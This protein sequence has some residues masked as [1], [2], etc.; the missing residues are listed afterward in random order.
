MFF[1]SLCGGQPAYVIDSLWIAVTEEPSGSSP[2]L[3]IIHTGDEVNVATIVDGQAQVKTATGRTGWVDASYLTPAPPLSTQFD[4]I[5]QSFQQQIDAIERAQARLQAL[6]QLA[7]PY[8]DESRPGLRWV[9]LA[10]GFIATCVA[11][12]AAGVSWRNRRLR[13]K[14][15]GLLP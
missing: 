12:F 8:I 15:G 10:A 14:W 4:Q 13:N 11:C 3:Q 5:E 1:S 6:E 9:W 2:A 7:Q